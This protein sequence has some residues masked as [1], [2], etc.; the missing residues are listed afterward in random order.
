MN[1]LTSIP[2]PDGDAATFDTLAQADRPDRSF[3]RARWFLSGPQP[4]TT[5]A[6]ARDPS[7]K[8]IAGFALRPKNI[9][10]TALGLDVNEI[11]GPYWPM[12]GVPLDSGVSAQALADAL[13]EQSLKKKLGRAFRLGP[14]VKD[15][16]SLRL[17]CKAAT[18]AGWTVL[19]KSAGQHFG[20]DLAALTA[21]GNWPSARGQKK[22]RWH[23]RNL[24]KIGPVRI[25]YFTGEDWSAATRDAIAAIEENS[26][27]GQ[28]EN[29]GDTKFRDIALRSTWEDAAN[30]PALAAMI[31]GSLFWVGDDPVAFT[32]G[33]D[34]GTSRLLI[35]N[36]F[37]QRFSKESP[38]KVLIYDD[39]TAAA[40]R[41]ITFMDLGMGDGGYKSYMGAQ[42][43]GAFVDLMFVRNP[44]FARVLRPLWKR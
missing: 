20:I 38:G 23:V 1:D 30:D 9:G 12:R 22:R 35:A 3:L 43:V 25:E 14:V 18:L 34:C 36:N 24:E 15:H 11:G 32:F 21:S 26:W 41:G 2:G 31:S 29:G 7:G 39:L 4:A 28:L 27:L 19:T 40:A 16:A 44:L 6:I 8:P 42:E 10:P 5:M 13:K 33:L 37:D 17:L